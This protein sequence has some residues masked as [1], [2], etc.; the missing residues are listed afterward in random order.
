MS[1]AERLAE[2]ATDLTHASTAA[3]LAIQ[4][5]GKSAQTRS[6]RFHQMLAA[7]AFADRALEGLLELIDVLRK[8]GV[9]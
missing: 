8:Q 6:A 5:Q 1:D 4:F 9:Q 3:S 2:L 7:A